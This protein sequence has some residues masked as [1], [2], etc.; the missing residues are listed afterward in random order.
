MTA[1][2]ETVAADTWSPLTLPDWRGRPF[3]YWLLLALLFSLGVRG[4]FGGGQ[5]L[6]APSGNLVGASTAELSGT[7]FRDFLIPGLVLSSVLGVVPLVVTAGAYRR[8][9]W[10]WVGSILVALAL[11]CWVVVEGA[12]IGF[13][14]RLQYPNLLQ[15]VGMLLIAGAPSVRA[16]FTD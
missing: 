3:L 16:Q 12:V 11:V 2:P 13:G 14:E 8:K 9:Q 6:I 7:P 4:V 1:L 15:A 10:A 5:F